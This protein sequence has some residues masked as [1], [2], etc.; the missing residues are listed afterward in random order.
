MP[1]SHLAILAALHGLTEALPVSR[2]GHGIVARLWLDGGAPAAAMTA[3]LHLGAALALAV[4]ARRR[5]LAALGEGARAVM[6]PSHFRGSAAAQDAL[7]LTLGAAV[8]L[9]TDALVAPRVEPWSESPTATG[10]GLCVTG[11]ALASTR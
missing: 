11:L 8:S 7:V 9:V 1:L 10:V 5:L 2:S 3:V 6:R 4:T